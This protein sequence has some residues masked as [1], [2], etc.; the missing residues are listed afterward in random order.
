M[1]LFHSADNLFSDAVGFRSVC[2]CTIMIPIG[3]LTRLDKLERVAREN[4]QRIL[5]RR[6]K[7]VESLTSFRCD[8][9]RDTQ[10][11][12]QKNYST[13]YVSHIECP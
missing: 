3:V 10:S 13:K 7:T 6:Q 5:F 4:N 12:R 11:L 2:G 8:S 1:S 9:K